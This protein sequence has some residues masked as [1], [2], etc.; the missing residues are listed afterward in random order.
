[1][2]LSF[3]RC[4][5]LR[6][7]GSF[8]VNGVL[9]ESETGY[10]LPIPENIPRKLIKELISEEDRL[11]KEGGFLLPT[12]QAVQNPRI[13]VA[14]KL[15]CK[16]VPFSLNLGPLTV[17]FSVVRIFIAD[18]KQ[19]EVRAHCKEIDKMRSEHNLKKTK[20]YLHFATGAYPTTVEDYI[21]E[22]ESEEDARYVIK[23]A[24]PNTS[25]EFV[26][27]KMLCFH[28]NWNSLENELLARNVRPYKRLADLKK[29]NTME[30]FCQRLTDNYNEH[31]RTVEEAFALTQASAHPIDLDP[32][33]FFK[34]INDE[35]ALELVRKIPAK[36]FTADHLHQATLYKRPKAFLHMFLEGAPLYG[37]TIPCIGYPES[38]SFYEIWKTENMRKNTT[39]SNRFSVI[40]V[41]EEA[42]QALQ[43]TNSH[44]FSRS[45]Y[46]HAKEL[47][48]TKAAHY[49]C[50]QQDPAGLKRT[51]CYLP[52][53]YMV[54]DENGLYE[55]LQ[56]NLSLLETLIRELPKG[57]D[58]D[59]FYGIQ[60]FP[61]SLLE[62]YVE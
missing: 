62:T 15:E 19:Y 24:P 58:E 5:N 25:L 35:E 20:R 30:P 28:P 33:K 61:V 51:D 57:F 44:C 8:S 6:V 56:K 13:I 36:E 16:G 41:E 3:S 55:D 60:E 14:T 38:F 18:K 4:Y 52:N 10:Q 54:K 21:R 43:K 17:T 22:L 47:K 45:L 48:W 50:M 26:L 37:L 34:N 42:L 29:N 40:K 59:D 31:Q 27:Y 11:R 1:M 23:K 53:E 9:E 12:F 2:S 32:L 46:E 7:A 39:Q 49:M